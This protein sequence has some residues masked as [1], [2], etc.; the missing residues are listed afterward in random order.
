MTH[1]RER[2]HNDRFVKLMD[3]H[4]PNWRETRDELNGAP[5]AEEVWL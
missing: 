4:L 1:F 3:K 5:L 2:T